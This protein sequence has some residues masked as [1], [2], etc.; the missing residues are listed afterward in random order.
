MGMRLF[1][2]DE[3]RWT[4]GIC[5]T[6]LNAENSPKKRQRRLVCCH[7][8]VNYFS[9]SIITIDGSPWK[10]GLVLIDSCA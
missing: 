7:R 6:Y 4:F 8:N 5:N 10:H 9:I 3:E 1:R 2:S